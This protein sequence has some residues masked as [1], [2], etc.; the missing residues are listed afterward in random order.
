MIPARTLSG[1]T[2]PAP[3]LP[4]G[5]LE[6]VAAWFASKVGSERA[7]IAARGAFFDEPPSS[8]LPSGTPMARIAPRFTAILAAVVLTAT[9]LPAQYPTIAQTAAPEPATAA[10]QGPAPREHKRAE[11]EEIEDLERQYGKAELEGDVAAMDKLLSDDY[12]GVNVNGELS[13]KRQQLDHMRTRSLVITKLNPSDVKIKLIGGQIAIV[14]S[15]VD[16][17]GTLDGT[18]LHGRYRTTRVYQRLPSG[19]WKVTS[20]E[21]TRIRRPGTPPAN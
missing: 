2:L 5:V 13:T 1:R 16:V 18:S 20:F 7:E 6:T 14:N 8:H 3:H 21:A 12:L 9:S 10:S 15:E 11:R 17:E 19:T 4:A